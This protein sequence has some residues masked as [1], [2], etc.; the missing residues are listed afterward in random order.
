M[1]EDARLWNGIVVP[2]LVWLTH[3]VMSYA[4]HASICES[5]SRTLVFII[6]IVFLLIVAAM[7]WLSFAWWR[8]QRDDLARFMAAMG[9]AS[10]CLF[11][12][13]ILS[14]VIPLVMLRPCD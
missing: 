3:L 6:T 13:L 12:L 14:D 7:G 11:A 1:S 2:P 8:S 5:K 9:F 4:L 10:S